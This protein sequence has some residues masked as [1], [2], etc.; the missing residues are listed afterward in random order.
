MSSHGEEVH[1]GHAEVI[2]VETACMGD[3]TGERWCEWFGSVRKDETR[4]RTWA[5]RQRWSGRDEFRRPAASRKEKEKM[6]PAA[7]A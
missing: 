7:R 3:F 4:W 6:V 2:V 5:I 1:G